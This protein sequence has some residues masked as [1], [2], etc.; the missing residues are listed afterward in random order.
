MLVGWAVVLL[1]A[2]FVVLPSR[3]MSRRRIPGRRRRLILGILAAS[4]LLAL[5]VVAVVPQTHLVAPELFGLQC[6]GHVCTDQP[7]RR[8][9]AAGLYD[10]AVADLTGRLGPVPPPHRVV[11]CST[12]AC[13]RTFD[14]G[15]STASTIADIGI[16]IGPRGW[17]PFYVRHE[18]IHHWQAQRLGLS[19]RYQDPR[20]LIEGMAYTLSDD[21]RRTLVEPNQ[22]YRRQFRSWYATIDHHEL[23]A[24]AA[25]E[26]RH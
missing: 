9:E 12:T 3:C 19:A 13:Y 23:W 26:T 17:E 14:T 11:F 7:N 15:Q 18:L 25:R 4:V 10:D 20:W 2:S 16:V 24:A 6:A 22:T 8:D 21:P 1:C 5:V